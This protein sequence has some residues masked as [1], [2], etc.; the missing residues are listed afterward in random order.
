MVDLHGTLVDKGWD[1]AEEV[2]N[3]CR[4]QVLHDKDAHAKINDM[5]CKINAHSSVQFC[6]NLNLFKLAQVLGY[7]SQILT[8]EIR[9]PV[10]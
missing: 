5:F 7:N 6:C 1:D 10:Q 2:Q 9:N 8:F 4:E 3:R